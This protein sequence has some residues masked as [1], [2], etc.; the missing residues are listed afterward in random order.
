MSG[1]ESG[2]KRGEKNLTF[3][4]RSVKRWESAG[5]CYVKLRGSKN[6]RLRSGLGKQ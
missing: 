5:R 3:R 6:D 2:K 1:G 4:Q